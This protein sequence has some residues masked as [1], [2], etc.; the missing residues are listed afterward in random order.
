MH[1]LQNF[2]SNYLAL[3][4]LHLTFRVAVQNERYD[5]WSPTLT[6]LRRMFNS[7]LPSVLHHHRQPGVSVPEA[8]NSSASQGNFLEVL[9]I[10]LNGRR[11]WKV[12]AKS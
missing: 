5:D 9:N 1:T 4:V 10:S 8:V 11:P 12:V 3:T 7:Y 2:I 6:R